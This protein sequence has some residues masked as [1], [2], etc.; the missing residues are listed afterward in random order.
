VSELQLED[1][2]DRLAG[3]TSIYAPR[4]IGPPELMR[5][6]LTLT[7]FALVVMTT[8][9]CGG[10]DGATTAPG[11]ESQKVTDVLA[12][13]YAARADGDAKRACGYM[14]P[15]WQAELIRLINEQPNNASRPPFRSCAAGMG[16][17]LRTRGARNQARNVQVNGVK[18]SGDSA[19]AKATRTASNGRTTSTTDYTLT[20]TAG[21]WKIAPGSG[22]TTISPIP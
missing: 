10:S 5:F 22:S 4:S 2:L 20:K 21:Q 15:G 14:S 13:Y 12:G 19:K 17:V 8:V 3:P 7:I 16:S 11:A 6:V 1:V 9:G 18:V